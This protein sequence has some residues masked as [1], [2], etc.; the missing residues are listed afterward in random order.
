MKRFHERKFSIIPG[1][2]LLLCDMQGNNYGLIVTTM[3]KFQKAPICTA[4]QTGSHALLLNTKFA[5][6][7]VA[8]VGMNINRVR[9]HHDRELIMFRFYSPLFTVLLCVIFKSVCYLR[10]EF[11]ALLHTMFCY[12][13]V[14]KQPAQRLKLRKRLLT[15]SKINIIRWNMY[16]DNNFHSRR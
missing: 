2:Y 14:W 4:S 11:W 16:R 1:L 12:M 7:A 6:R 9:L 8:A 13:F 10:A 3:K 5:V 15:S